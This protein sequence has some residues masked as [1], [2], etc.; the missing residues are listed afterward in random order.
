MSVSISELTSASAS[1]HHPSALSDESYDMQIRNLVTYFRQL[2]S[3]KALDAFIGD[4]SLF[5][6]SEDVQL[7]SPGQEADL[8]PL[9]QH[10]D[11]QMDSIAYLFILRLQIQGIRERNSGT[12]LPDLQPAGKVW[13]RS[14]D[15]LRKFNS[16][17]VR[18]AG[19]EW[20]RLVEFIGQAAQAA[21]KESSPLS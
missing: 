8:S 19:Q 4:D 9:L 16:I 15:F 5:D 6:V 10:F 17:Q 14:T 21:A 7:I 3:S 20:R 1:L 13:S 2:L 11:P 12:L 18:Y